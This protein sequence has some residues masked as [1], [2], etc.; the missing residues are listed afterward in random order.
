MTEML[1]IIKSELLNGKLNMCTDISNISKINWYVMK[2]LS[3]T[4]WS[5]SE[6]ADVKLILEISN[7][8]YNNTDRSL[9]V[10]DDGVYDILLEKYKRYDSNYQV[11]APPVHFDMNEQLI[12]KKSHKAAP[13][14]IIDK[15]D[16]M[17]FYDDLKF[18]YHNDFDRHKLP[19]YFIKGKENRNERSIAHSYP[20]LVGT[21]DKCKF[22]LNQDAKDKGVFDNSNVKVFERELR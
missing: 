8:L 12:S 10:L 9:L 21:L 19:P 17:V 18:D 13:Y 15:A 11:G 6:I 2:L 5:P 22:T 20:D 3:Q 14:F 16:S 1:S 7:I 4:D